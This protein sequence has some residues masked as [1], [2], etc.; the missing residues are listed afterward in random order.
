MADN[1]GDYSKDELVRL[2]RE[3]DR[4]PR[5]GLAWERNEIEHDKAINDDFMVLDFGAGLPCGDAPFRNLII[6]G[7]NFD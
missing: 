5:F 3:R 4:K 2:L 6:E 7:D 1:Y